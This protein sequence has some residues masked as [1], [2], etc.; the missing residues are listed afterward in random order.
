MELKLLALEAA[1]NDSEDITCHL[2][3]GKWHSPPDYEAISYEWS[4][5]ELQ[6]E[7][8]CDTSFVK[9][10]KNLFEAL[11]AVRYP[12][13]ARLLWIDCF[14]LTRD[15]PELDLLFDIFSKAKSVIIWLGKENSMT[16]T[17]FEVMN[18]LAYISRERHGAGMKGD[19]IFPFI[20]RDRP[21]DRSLFLNKQDFACICFND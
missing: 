16:K 2:R 8:R 19:D 5:K 14:G 11:R 13:R 9:I 18:S 21:S 12:D 6:C 15:K 17:A 20:M 4:H 1:E 7:V 10:S 3:H